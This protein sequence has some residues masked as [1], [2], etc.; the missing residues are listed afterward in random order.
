[1]NRIYKK[2]KRLDILVNAAGVTLPINESD[3]KEK[4][5]I[6]FDKIIKVILYTMPQ[7]CF[8]FLMHLPI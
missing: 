5:V 7:C 6:K 4:I 8:L 3:C 2:E 1:M